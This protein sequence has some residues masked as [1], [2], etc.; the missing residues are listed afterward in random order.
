MIRAL[1]KN[2]DWTYNNHFNQLKE[3]AQN[4]KTRLLS[5]K[6][7]WFIDL[8]S[9]IDWWSILGQRGNESI[10]RSEITRVTLATANVNEILNL[11]II[12]NQRKASI[13]LDVATDFGDVK[14]EFEN[15]V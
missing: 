5:F 9:H 8:E 7:D 11:E 3:V 12:V 4:L 14:M 1:N 15:G 10:I 2:H 13:K 6:S